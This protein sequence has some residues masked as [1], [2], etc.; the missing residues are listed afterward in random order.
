[1]G[2]HMVTKGCRIGKSVAALSALVGLL[3]T[4]G[5]QVALEIPGLPKRPA[6]FLTSERIFLTMLFQ[7]S[8]HILNPFKILEANVTGRFFSVTVLQ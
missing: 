1:M 5:Q 3:P 2:A 4:V 8:Q 6:A 7:M